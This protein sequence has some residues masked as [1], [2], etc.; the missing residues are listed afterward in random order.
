[1][2][3]TVEQWLA[4][5]PGQHRRINGAAPRLPP[6]RVHVCA[7]DDI[8]VKISD[9]GGGIKKEWEDNVFKFGWSSVSLNSNGEQ[10][11]GAEA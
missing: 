10:P 1:M 7:G 11:A 9:A 4:V 3:A 2:R 8:T 6:V 5:T